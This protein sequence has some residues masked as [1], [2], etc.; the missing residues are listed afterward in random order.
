[1]RNRERKRTC[2]V[3]GSHKVKSLQN[4]NCAHVLRGAGSS[5]SPLLFFSLVACCV[6]GGEALKSLVMCG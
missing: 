6:T 3:R 5:E 1:M 4:C 2:Q